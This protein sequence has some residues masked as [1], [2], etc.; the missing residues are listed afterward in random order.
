[1]PITVHLPNVLAPLAGGQ[2]QLTAEGRTVGDVIDAL[3]SRYPGLGPRLRDASGRP[4]EFV[5][6]YRNDEDIRLAGGFAGPVRDGDQLTVV[7]AV[8]GG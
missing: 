8:A 1:M 7:P 6:I 4:Y 3:A 2:R 5:T